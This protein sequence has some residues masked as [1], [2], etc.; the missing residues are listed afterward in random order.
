[1]VKEHPIPFTE[2]IQSWLSIFRQCETVL[3]T[4]AIAGEKVLALTALSGKTIRF[5]GS[6]FILSRAVKQLKQRFLIQVSELVFR[7][8]EVIAGVDIAI[9]LHYC[10][11]SAF[12]PE[13]TYSRILP[14]PESQNRFEKLNKIASH[15]L[16]DPQSGTIAR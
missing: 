5:H 13:S 16:P 14:I 3:R 4:L 2:V 9:E 12:L 8:Y 1:M 15:I 7:R 6:E 10:R 11:V